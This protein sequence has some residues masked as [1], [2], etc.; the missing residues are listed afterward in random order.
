M[1]AKV[2]TLLQRHG[3]HLS[4][5]LGQNFLVDEHVAER[6]VQ[7]SGVSSDD[8]VIEIG[9]GL[10]VLTRALAAR[11]RRVVT[12]EI[13]SGLVRALEAEHL[14]PESVQ[15]VHDDALRL[16]LESLL[17]EDA[18]PARL[19]A[20]LPYSA[21]TPLL[22]RLLDLR[23][24]LEDWSVMVQSELADRLSATVGSKAYGSFAVLHALCVDAQ[25]EM[26]LQ[27]ASFFPAPKVDSSF[28]RIWPRR[29][30]PLAHGDDPG[31]AGRRELR[32]VERVVRAAFS[33]RRK[34]IANC[35][36]S[37]GFAP[38]GDREHIEAALAEAGIDPRH[39]AETVAP[40]QFV[41]LTRALL[42]ENAGEA[43]GAPAESGA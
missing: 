37:G 2:R 13:D 3:L 28:V 43:V 27:G 36:R 20:N 10:G 21:A 38:R 8:L 11:A 4:R 12:V 41:T 26:T 30:T 19:V 39:R 15:L 33:Q 24:R 22:R 14:L 35:L 1:S 25:T 9:T 32:R 34:T 23:H 16:D 17:G 29:R 5:D 42:S 6:L 7:L 31:G 40:E 18:G